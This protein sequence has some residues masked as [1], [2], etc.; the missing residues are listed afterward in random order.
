ML[1]QFERISFVVVPG[2]NLFAFPAG[3]TQGACLLLVQQ[4]RH[5]PG[6]WHRRVPMRVSTKDTNPECG[7]EGCP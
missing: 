5:Q 7:T 6:M 3:N 2:K 4:E 1:L